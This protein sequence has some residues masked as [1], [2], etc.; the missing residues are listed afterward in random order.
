MKILILLNWKSLRQDISSLFIGA[1]VVKM[2]FSFGDQV[3]DE[4][5]TD[6]YMFGTAVHNQNFCNGDSGLIITEHISCFTWSLTKI[7]N[8]SSKPDCLRCWSGCN[9]VRLCRQK[10]YNVLFLW[11]PGYCTW[12]QTKHLA[13]GALPVIQGTSQSL[14]VGLIVWSWQH[15]CI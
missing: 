4:I 9:I 3:S 2:Y 1:T 5:E 8:K 10:S 13:S 15:N 6:L 12:P 11:A 7:N 14:S